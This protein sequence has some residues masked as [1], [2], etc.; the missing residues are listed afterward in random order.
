MNNTMATQ[1]ESCRPVT[2]ILISD[3]RDK[4]STTLP[5]KSSTTIKV[6]KT[7]CVEESE[8]TV[9]FSLL[10][11]CNHKEGRVGC[12]HQHIF[13]RKVTDIAFTS[14]FCNNH[15]H[16]HVPSVLYL[17]SPSPKSQVPAHASQFY[18]QLFGLAGNQ[19]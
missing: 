10:E 7:P 3:N 13:T 5:L 18:T 9:Q 6:A 19:I 2:P 14:D 4:R 1:Q 17:M 15:S 12:V 11:Y 8:T 16:P